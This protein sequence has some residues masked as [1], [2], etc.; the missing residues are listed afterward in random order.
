MATF[1]ALAHQ[2]GA[3]YGHT[4]LFLHRPK[5][6]GHTADGDLADGTRYGRH[7]LGDGGEVVLFALQVRAGGVAVLCGEALVGFGGCHS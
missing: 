5:H 1:Q 2:G 4:V 7:A 3:T 6:G